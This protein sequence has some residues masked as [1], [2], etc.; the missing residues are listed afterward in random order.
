MKAL[1]LAALLV[2]N[3]SITLVHASGAIPGDW[4]DNEWLHRQLLA[5]SNLGDYL[6]A[7][8]AFLEQSGYRLDHVVLQHGDTGAQDVRPFVAWVWF[9][10]RQNFR[11]RISGRMREHS[12]QTE[13]V[14]AMDNLAAVGY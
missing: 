8:E 9:R 14:I 10:G 5:Q 2:L 13:D 4:G 1:L 6:R 12:D 3:S 7:S 11:L